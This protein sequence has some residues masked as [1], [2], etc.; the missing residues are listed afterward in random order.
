[1]QTLFEMDPRV[2]T[3]NVSPYSFASDG[4]NYE[5]SYRVYLYQNIRKRFKLTGIASKINCFM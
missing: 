3:D 1:M 5:I 4:I 2:D